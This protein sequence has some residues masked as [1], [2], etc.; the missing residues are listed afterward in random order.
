MASCYPA[1]FIFLECFFCLCSSFHSSIASSGPQCETSVSAQWKHVPAK[2]IGIRRKNRMSHFYLSHNII[3]DPDEF[4]P[5]IFGWI[6]IS[7]SN[8]FSKGTECNLLVQGCLPLL[9]LPYCTHFWFGR[10][11][12]EQPVLSSRWK[13]TDLVFRSIV[14]DVTARIFQVMFHIGPLTLCIFHCFFQISN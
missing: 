7:M 6:R 2:T 3:P 10:H 11:I 13:G 14:G 1:R 12:T 8:R 9:F 5:S 4:S